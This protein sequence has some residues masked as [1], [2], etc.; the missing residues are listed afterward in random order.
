[1]ENKYAQ[2]WLSFIKDSDNNPKLRSYKL[3]KNNFKLE[4]YLLVEPIVAKRRTFSKLRLSAHSLH[5]E[6]GRFCKPKTPVQDRICN[7][8]KSSEIE[9]ELH[10]TIK[11]TL[12]DK[13]R[14]N[15]YK[16]LNSFT[17]FRSLTDEE[18]FKFLMSGN[19]GDS[20][21]IHLHLNEF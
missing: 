4:N 5:I 19:D 12:Y 16:E 7:Y 9:D 21:V 17:N 8:C 14:Q 2:Q 6:T 1:M 11:C 3:F 15:L 18:K 13:E 10:F 20:E